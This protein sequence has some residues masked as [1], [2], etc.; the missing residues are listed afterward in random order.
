MNCEHP[1]NG[2][3]CNECPACRGIEDGSVLD[4]V[5]LDAA[6]N[7][8]VD[9]VRMLRDEAVFSPTTVRKRVYI[10]DEVH[11]TAHQRGFSVSRTSFYV[12]DVIRD[13]SVSQLVVERVK[14]AGGIR[15]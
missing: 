2:N 7:N 11:D 6:S 5:E 3:P 10:I 13:P 12:P 8:G 14:T 1:V 15:S 9:D 4:V